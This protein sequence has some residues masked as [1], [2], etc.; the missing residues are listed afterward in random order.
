MDLQFLGPKVIFYIVII[1]FLMPV[2][3]AKPLSVQ[4]VSSTLASG[5]WR[6]EIRRSDGHLIVFNFDIRQSAG[7]IRVTIIN[8]NEHLLVDDI[9]QLGDS[10]FIEMPFFDSHFALRIST[11]HRL[12]GS[13]I[14]NYGN[15]L[16]V[17]PFRAIFNEAWR[18][19]VITPPAFNITGRWS[20]LF[21]EDGDTTISVGEFYQTGSLVR[22]TF[23][24]ISGDYRYL[25]GVVSGDTLKLSAFDGGHAYS[26]ESRILDSQKM[27]GFFY[28]GATSVQSWVGEKN[29]NAKLP[30]EFSQTRLK[31][32][33]NAHLHFTFPDLNGHPVSLSDPR[34]K[35]KV[36][37]VQILGSW[38]PNCMD[39]TRFLSNW[40]RQN[41][42]KDVAIVGLAYERTSSF[43][44]A[45]KLLKPFVIR[46]HVTYPILA[47][48][49][50]VND[51]LRTEKTLP[52]IQEIVA[53]PTTIFIDK[54]GVVQKIHTGFNG[55]GTGE[56]YEAYKKEFNKLVNKLVT[57]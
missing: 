11:E 49:V 33:A 25:D 10:V 55:P 22:G 54:K 8:G 44:N 47:T 37:I 36:V 2:V 32:S 57:E 14:K 31:D 23:L 56:H 29:K 46:F 45:Q 40:F 1:F 18:F 24:T 35:N 26:F 38:C 39:E 13:W 30:D 16:V 43:T 42:S 34:F 27:V 15:R 53:F 5:T 4:P 19:P 17:L 6:G 12:E 51:S 28:A 50:T 21:K 7:K 52:E 41:K 9:H 3:N 48:G 20:V